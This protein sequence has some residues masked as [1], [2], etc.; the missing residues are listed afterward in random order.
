MGH[1]PQ[2][3]SVCLGVV[4]QHGAAR[5]E[6][7]LIKQRH[8]PLSL[9]HQCIRIHLKIPEAVSPTDCTSNCAVYESVAS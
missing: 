3:P 4:D 1:D 9:F 8:K 2:P 5:R 7:G 6:T